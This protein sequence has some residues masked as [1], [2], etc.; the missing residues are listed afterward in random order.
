MI[1]LFRILPN[2][3]RAF[4]VLGLVGSIA[5]GLSDDHPQVLTY[6]AGRGDFELAITAEG[7][8]EA[9]KT[10]TIVTPQL[11]WTSPQ[12]A[13][14]PPEGAAVK[15][16]DVIAELEAGEIERIYLNAL[17]EV[18]IARAEAQKVEAELNLQ[19]VQ[20]QSQLKNTQAALEV[21]KLQLAKLTFEPAKIQEIRKLEISRDEI[22]TQKIQNK[23]TAIQDIQKAERARLQLK[24]KQAEN[25]LEQSRFLLNQL[26]LKA[27]VDGF[28]LYAES[29]FSGEKIAVGN[30]LFPGMPIIEIPDLS[31]MQVKMFVS[32]TEAQRLQK[33]QKAVI[34]VANL[35]DLTFTGKVTKVDKMAKPIKRRSKVKKVEVLV[36][37]DSSLADLAPGLT[38]E[39]RITT[40]KLKDVITLPLEC[41]FQK[42]SLK[43]V[44]VLDKSHYVPCPVTVQYYGNDFVAVQGDLKG[45][46]KC[47]LQEPRS[48]T[49]RWPANLKMPERP[50]IEDSLKH[51]QTDDSLLTTKTAS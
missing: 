24:I 23:L 25:K 38:A 47:A 16:G 26:Q 18:E 19:R 5:C 20:L 17:D 14:L 12:I 29:W 42:D 32:E 31:K 49:V 33:D 10:H 36:E 7:V 15:K 8:I 41:L 6:P 37:I 50:V 51:F 21:S 11:R 2:L 48:A 34:S 35:P 30:Q 44:Y 40:T 45:G 43:V 46:E 3:H 27:P 28:V 39:C 1:C 13:W 22:E 9:T 4:L